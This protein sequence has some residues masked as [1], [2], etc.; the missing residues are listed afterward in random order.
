MVDDNVLGL[1]ARKAVLEEH[2]Y[3]VT[4][5]PTPEEALETISNGT[6]DLLITDYKMPGMNGDDLIRRVREKGITTP[7]IML[8]GFVDPLGLREANT[9]A[10]VVLQK[11][12]HEV[13]HL[14]RAVRNLLRPAT[15][16]K[17]V[18]S[19]RPASKPSRKKA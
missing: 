9:G 18:G 11:S 10:D 6:F 8:S 12:N 13:N 17:A 19:E 14:V 1:D 15:P 7:A 2:G 5:V 3:R 4:T 16:R